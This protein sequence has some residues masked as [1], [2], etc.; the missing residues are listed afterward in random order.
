M[1]MSE[2]AKEGN[3]IS[4]D[5]NYP[6]AFESVEEERRKRKLSAALHVFGKSGFD[7]GVAGHFTARDPGRQIRSPVISVFSRSTM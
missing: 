2:A 7:E 5:V 3:D 1:S 6:P 4:G